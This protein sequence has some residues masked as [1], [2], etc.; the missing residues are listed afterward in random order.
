VLVEPDRELPVTDRGVGEAGHGQMTAGLVDQAGRQGVLVAV[1]PAEQ[2]GPPPCGRVTMARR[3]AG[4]RWGESHA[5]IKRC[6]RTRSPSRGHSTARPQPRA[7]SAGATPEGTGYRQPPA[8]QSTTTAVNT[9]GLGP[10]GPGALVGDPGRGQGVAPQHRPV[11]AAVV[12]HDP[13][14]GDPAAGEPGVRALPE[15]CRR[16]LA[17]ISQALGVGQ[18]GVVIDRGVQLG[19]ADPAAM[20]AAG[21]PS[22][23]WPPRWMRMGACPAKLSEP[24]ET[25]AILLSG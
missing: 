4:M 10:V 19:V 17:L 2:I 22:T 8:G 9:H 24:V 18:P 3:H 1:D 25:G 5:A 15:P 6:R 13:L 11:A 20:L 12:G 21:R 16:L 14:H 23:L 7:R